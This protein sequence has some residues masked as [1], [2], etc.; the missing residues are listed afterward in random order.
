[1]TGKRRGRT[2]ARPVGDSALALDAQGRW[3]RRGA[4]N[5]AA[6]RDFV[7]DTPDIGK[8]Q[9]PAAEPPPFLF[10]LDDPEG[11]PAGGFAVPAG[12]RSSDGVWPTIDFARM[13][14]TLE[15]PPPAEPPLFWRGL[16]PPWRLV[17][18][19]LLLGA[20][21][22]FLLR[23]HSGA[24]GAEEAAPPPP[25][26]VAPAFVPLAPQQAER[27][28]AAAAVA[29]P[30]PRRGGMIAAAG[31]PETDL[32]LPLPPPSHP[33]LL[34]VVADEPVAAVAAPSPA[35]SD[36]EGWFSLAEEYLELGDANRAEAL[37]LQLYS[38]GAQRGR[39][40]VALGDLCAGRKDFKRAE[41]YYRAAKQLYQ[42]NTRPATLP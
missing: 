36:E 35:A 26:S 7:L 39:A 5:E 29:E 42:D 4:A 11:N 9:P 10:R 15:S 23:S 19:A 40:A 3:V 6:P 2:S 27:H 32:A 13:A 20:A 24:G 38:E 30:A 25:A 1:M 34:Q 21:V 28:P 18:G 22:L 31:V 33:G 37:Y 17:G 41:E 14:P 12:D 16:S 8:M